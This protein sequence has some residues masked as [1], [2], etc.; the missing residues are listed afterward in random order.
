[1]ATPAVE[2]G[3]KIAI[4]RLL[5]RKVV[6]LTP[7]GCESLLNRHPGMFMTW[8]IGSRMINNDVLMRRY[9]NPN[10]DLKPNAMAM[11]VTRGDD[12]YAAS[13]NAFIMRLQPLN[14]P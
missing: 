6:D 7:N 4:M 11:L 1:M 13:R 8:V 14:L 9:S 2:S 3:E 12:G 10:V 5:G